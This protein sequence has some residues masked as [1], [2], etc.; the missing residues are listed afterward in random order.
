MFNTGKATNG[1]NSDNNGEV[2]LPGRSGGSA[3]KVLLVTDSLQLNGN[4]FTISANGGDG[5]DGQHGGDG[6]DGKN[7]ADVQGQPNPGTVYKA[8][9]CT[10]ESLEKELRNGGFRFSFY[11]YVVHFERFEYKF[12]LFGE[13]GQRASNGGD[14]G[15]AGRGGNHRSY[16]TILLK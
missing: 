10:Q 4:S 14:G 12:T 16:E 2:G 7:G 3:G 6:Y 8:G 11:K 13:D 15:R 5:S 1:K 9:V